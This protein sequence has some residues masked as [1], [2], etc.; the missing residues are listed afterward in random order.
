M[1]AALSES[2]LAHLKISASYMI[3]QP[4]STRKF[5]SYIYRHACLDFL[6]IPLTTINSSSVNTSFSSCIVL[7]SAL[8][9]GYHAKN[10]LLAWQ[11]KT[12]SA[13]INND[14]NVYLK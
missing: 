1:M 10:G 6:K 3:Q 12:V 11:Y 8:F 5:V 9:F 4:K 13:T 7:R 2:I 14:P